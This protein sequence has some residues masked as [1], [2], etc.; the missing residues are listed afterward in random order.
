MLQLSMPVGGGT[1]T[2]KTMTLSLP[3]EQLPDALAEEARR[4]ARKL[5]L[6]SRE[7]YAD[8]DPEDES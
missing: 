2:Q 4:I 1:W 3:E 5:L 8:D 6:D 7:E